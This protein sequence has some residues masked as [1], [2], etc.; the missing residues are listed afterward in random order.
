MQSVKTDSPP[1]Q[2]IIQHVHI[3]LNVDVYL[4]DHVIGTWDRYQRDIELTGNHAAHWGVE[5]FYL[6]RC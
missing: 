6:C 4:A 1:T 3:L 2:V 5:V